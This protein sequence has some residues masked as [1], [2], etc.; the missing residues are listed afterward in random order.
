MKADKSKMF[1]VSIDKLKA[2][3]AAPFPLYLFF[4]RNDR[5]IPIR[6]PGDPIGQAKFDLFL[7]RQH[8]ELWVPNNFQEIFQTYLQYVERNGTP[9]PNLAQAEAKAE[10]VPPAA[11]KSEQAEMV[12][13]VLADEDL[14]SEEKAEVLSA[15]SQDMMRALNQITTESPS[16]PIPTER[17]PRA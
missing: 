17:A 6:L 16:A 1:P 14:S 2:N 7:Q 3:D 10:Q 12:G 5:F 11:P 15:V 8:L 4:R 9:V 13:D